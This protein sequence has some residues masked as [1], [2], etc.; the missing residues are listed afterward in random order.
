MSVEPV[1]YIDGFILGGAHRQDVEVAELVGDPGVELAAGIPAVAGVDVAALS[2]AARG[3]GT[4]CSAPDYQRRLKDGAAR[5]ALDG[6]RALALS[7]HQRQCGLE[8]AEPGG[9]T[10]TSVHR[11]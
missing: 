8:R 9:G 1:Q 7:R 4:Y 11:Q 2:A 5:I 10:S 3:S 6:Q